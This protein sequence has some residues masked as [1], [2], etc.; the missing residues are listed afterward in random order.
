MRRERE[1]RQRGMP[2]RLKK[3]EAQEREKEK[4]R[5]RRRER[6]GERGGEYFL[7]LTRA[8]K[9]CKEKR[10]R[11]GGVKERRK[12]GMGRDASL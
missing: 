7:P 12:E 8:Y 9:A 4:E 1:E 10:E 11:R 2:L 6:E 3:R 5:E